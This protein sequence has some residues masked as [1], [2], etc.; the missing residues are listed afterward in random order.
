MLKSH[1]HWLSLPL[2][3][4]IEFNVICL[5]P[6]LAQIIVMTDSSLNYEKVNSQNQQQSGISLP[7]FEEENPVSDD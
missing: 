7:G 3:K 5:V 4:I 6:L 1:H 2:R